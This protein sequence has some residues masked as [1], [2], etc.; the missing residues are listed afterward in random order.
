MKG[1]PPAV[2]AARTLA[3]LRDRGPVTAGHHSVT[4][5]IADATGCTLERARRRLDTLEAAGHIRTVRTSPRRIV[6]VEAATR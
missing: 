2:W 1:G 3:F 4:R 6:R 5:Q